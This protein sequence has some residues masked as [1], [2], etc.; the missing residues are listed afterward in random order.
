MKTLLCR[1]EEVP[2]CS[3]RGE[4]PS[5]SL[6]P[7]AASLGIKGSWKS[8][9]LFVLKV[10][11]SQLGS[12]SQTQSWFTLSKVWESKEGAGTAEQ[13]SG[14]APLPL[15]PSWH[16][17]ETRDLSHQIS[18]LCNESTNQSDTFSLRGNLKGKSETAGVNRTCKIAKWEDGNFPKRKSQRCFE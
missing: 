17:S 1:Q 4:K 18:Y 8:N 5:L 13:R 12:R 3:F 15:P 9:L 11:R 16:N 7:P 6:S 10:V 2:P 14:C